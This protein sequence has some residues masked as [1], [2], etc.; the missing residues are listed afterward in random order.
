MPENSSPSHQT[1]PASSAVRS[2]A[3]SVGNTW[4]NRRSAG[5]VRYGLRM[6][7]ML[8]TPNTTMN[9]SHNTNAVGAPVLVSVQ[10]ASNT[11][12]ATVVVRKL[13]RI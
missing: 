6:A 2:V 13:A 4:R 10:M 5:L 8:S 7:L 12:M 3:D 1:V 11:P 9:S